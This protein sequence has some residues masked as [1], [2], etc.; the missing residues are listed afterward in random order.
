MATIAQVGAVGEVNQDAVA[1]RKQDEPKPTAPSGINQ[2]EID[3]SSYARVYHPVLPII[4][5]ARTLCLRSR[6]P[7]LRHVAW[8]ERPDYFCRTSHKEEHH[9]TGRVRLMLI[10]QTFGAADPLWIL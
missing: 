1:I 4:P 8:P 10:S 5:V 2:V 7:G 9:C 3:L 6:Q